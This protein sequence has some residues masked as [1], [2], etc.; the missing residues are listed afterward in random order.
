LVLQNQDSEKDHQ[1]DQ[2]SN[3]AFGIQRLELAIPKQDEN[4]G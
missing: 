4:Q 3:P 2:Y 1:V